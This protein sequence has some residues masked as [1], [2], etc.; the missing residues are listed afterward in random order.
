MPCHLIGDVHERFNEV[1]AVPSQLLLNSLT[2]EYAG[3]S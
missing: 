2:G 3:D 1:V